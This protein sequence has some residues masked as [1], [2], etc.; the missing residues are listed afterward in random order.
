MMEQLQGDVW[1]TGRCGFQVEGNHDSTEITRGNYKI[2]GMI[3]PFMMYVSDTIFL[4]R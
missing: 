1:L 3:L 2:M 4:T